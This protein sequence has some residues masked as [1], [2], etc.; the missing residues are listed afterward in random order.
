MED[1]RMNMQR[2]AQESAAVAV[3]VKAGSS[4]EFERDLM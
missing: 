1:Q 4:V 3:R 2:R